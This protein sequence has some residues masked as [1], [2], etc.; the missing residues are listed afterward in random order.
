MPYKL[1][2]LNEKAET[3]AEVKK[4]VKSK[5]LIAK[6]YEIPASTLSTFLQNEKKKY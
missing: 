3:I 6:E 4:G 1:L 5:S 2:S